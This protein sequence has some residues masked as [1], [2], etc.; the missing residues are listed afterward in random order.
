VLALERLPVHHKD[1]FDR[2]LIAQAMTENAILISHDPLMSKYPIQ[3]I[4]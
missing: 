1:P 2:L 4:W 3:V